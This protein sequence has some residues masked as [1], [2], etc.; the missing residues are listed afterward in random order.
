MVTVSVAAN[1]AKD[2]TSFQFLSVDNNPALTINVTATI[3]GTVINAIVPFGTDR[4]ALVAAFATTGDTVKVGS[5][6]QVSGET[7]N[8]FSAA[9]EYIVTAANG[10][11]Q[12]YTVTVDNSQSNTKNITQ[13]TI[14]GVDGIINGTNIALTLPNGTDRT[15]LIPTTINITGASVSPA[16]GTPNN[17]TTPRTYTVTAADNTTKAYTVTVTIAGTGAKDITRFTINGLDAIIASTGPTTG[18]I[19]LNMPNGTVLTNLAPVVTITGVSVLP[20]SGDAVDFSN[21]VNYVVTAEDGTTKTYVVNVGVVNGNGTKIISSFT[22]LGVSGIINNGSSASVTLVLP[23]GT[24]LS[25][26]TPTIVINASSIS[27]PSRV[28]QD[29]RNPVIYTVTAADGSTRVYTVTVTTL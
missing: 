27:P 28:P 3:T 11:T 6:A 19:T 9:V 4:S 12:T 8:D 1:S 22:I 24:D 2:I 5:V 29:F 23:A 15:A 20:V 25:A 13:F 26:Q 16:A 21:P 17:F 14:D 10:T 18:V 7:P